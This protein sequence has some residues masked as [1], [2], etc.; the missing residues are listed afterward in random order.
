MPAI[1]RKK[2]VL[3]PLPS[4]ADLLGPNHLPTK[5]DLSVPLNDVRDD[6]DNKDKVNGE[7]SSSPS[8][9][10]KQKI[11]DDTTPLKDVRERHLREHVRKLNAQ[12][13][14]TSSSTLGK[15][16]KAAAAAWEEPEVYLVEETGEVF[17]EY[18]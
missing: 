18:E 6:D 14:E 5:A 13:Q 11:I 16:K 12:R 7:P 17:L 3:Y 15:N 2:V 8:S 9:S 4:A 1:G 10:A